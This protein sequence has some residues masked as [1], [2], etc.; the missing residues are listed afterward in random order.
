MR[1]AYSG[2]ASMS[3]I[4]P[5]TRGQL[6]QFSVVNSSTRATRGKARSTILKEASA[7]LSAGSSSGLPFK[8]VNVNIASVSDASDDAMSGFMLK[9]TRVV[10]P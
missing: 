7:V 8:A 9:P 2:S 6:G 10:S 3:W 5:A 4:Y 1:S